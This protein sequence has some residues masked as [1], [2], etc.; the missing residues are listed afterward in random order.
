MATPEETAH[1]L[2]EE[3]SEE[4]REV[5]M[6]TLRLLETGES[7]FEMNVAKEHPEIDTS[8]LRQAASNY[9]ARA[10]AM[11]FATF[12]WGRCRERELFEQN[13]KK[14]CQLMLSMEHPSERN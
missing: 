9:A 1:E 8:I 3:Y 12:L 2:L 10:A 14:A 13:V 5:C 4:C 6:A 11:A 7:M